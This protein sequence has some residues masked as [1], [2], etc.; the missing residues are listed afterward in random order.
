MKVLDDGSGL[1][2]DIT[3]SS[4]CVPA[5]GV[6]ELEI[7]LHP[8]VPGSFDTEVYIGI[9]ESKPLLLRVTGSVEMPKI[10]VVQVSMHAQYCSCILHFFIL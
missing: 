3:P 9:R 5:K 7:S 2:M 4:G 8:T 6:M 10:S 1:N